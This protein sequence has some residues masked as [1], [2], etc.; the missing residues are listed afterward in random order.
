MLFLNRDGP[1]EFPAAVPDQIAFALRYR[2]DFGFH[3]QAPERN[4]SLAL[5][6]AVNEAC[7][8]TEK[9]TRA[10]NERRIHKPLN[11]HAHP[12]GRRV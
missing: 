4:L 3:C 10:A 1:F 7:L 8:M 5:L 12:K 9:K 11:N 6:E 2:G